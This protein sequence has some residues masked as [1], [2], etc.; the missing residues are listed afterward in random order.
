MGIT[1]SMLTGLIDFGI[2]TFTGFQLIEQIISSVLY[3]CKASI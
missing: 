2:L 1:N 3:P